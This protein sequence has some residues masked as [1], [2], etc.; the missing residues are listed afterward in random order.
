MTQDLF[1]NIS[2]PNGNPISLLTR[3]VVASAPTLPLT[4]SN[5]SLRRHGSIADTRPP[6]WYQRRHSRRDVARQTHAPFLG[7]V[8]PNL[9][10]RPLV[11]TTTR[12]LP[13][14]SVVKTPSWTLIF[15]NSLRLYMI[16]LSGFSSILGAF[17][18][19]LREM[20]NLAAVAPFAHGYRCTGSRW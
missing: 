16:R 6:P 14:P 4:E 15:S 2:R 5:F 20:L 11:E 19:Y 17:L 9:W 18:F 12:P 7:W 1:C 3:Q 13:E 8:C 10:I